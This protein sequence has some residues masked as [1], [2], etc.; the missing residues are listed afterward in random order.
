MP[1]SHDAVAEHLSRESEEYR[2]LSEKHQSFEEKLKSLNARHILSEEEKL[3][4]VKLKK[5]K[6]ALKDR[7]AE[8]AR[9]FLG[10]PATRTG[11]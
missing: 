9:N 6:L 7:M 5:R 2:R 10:S 3:E 1:I 4:A 8:I 11:R